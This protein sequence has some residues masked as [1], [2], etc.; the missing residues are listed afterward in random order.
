MANLDQGSLGVFRGPYT[1]PSWGA[2]ELGMDK[3]DE[4][5]QLGI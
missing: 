1:I 5:R 3:A 2:S 4:V